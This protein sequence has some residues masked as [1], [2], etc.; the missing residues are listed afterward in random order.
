MNFWN[1]IKYKT[2]MY[3]MNN[4]W[5]SVW[6]KFHSSSLSITAR[7]PHS[8]WQAVLASS[9]VSLLLP[10]QKHRPVRLWQIHS[11]IND[12][13]Q[14]YRSLPEMSVAVWRIGF[15]VVLTVVNFCEYIFIS[16]VYDCTAE[17]SVFASDV[18]WFSL[19][20]MS[21]AHVY[22]SCF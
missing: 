15:V 17:L 1:Q 22:T 7:S 13:L 8:D 3:K 2:N 20:K 4:Y 16:G 19:Y 21:I 6:T 5:N 10:H 9:Q 14:H 18:K 12:A 11:A